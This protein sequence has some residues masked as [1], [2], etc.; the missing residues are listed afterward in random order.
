MTKI[1]N[2]KSINY[3]IIDFQSETHLELVL[4]FFEEQ[5]LEFFNRAK[6]GLLKL[7]MN[8]VCNK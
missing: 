2:T 8:S 5:S 1:T 3:S 7:R 6:K 4:K